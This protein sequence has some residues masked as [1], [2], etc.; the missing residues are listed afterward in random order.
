[1]LKKYFR[2]YQKALKYFIN[3]KNKQFYYYFYTREM[4]EH[5]IVDLLDSFGVYAL[6]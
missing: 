3:C 6:C 2:L 1:M 4:V 5:N